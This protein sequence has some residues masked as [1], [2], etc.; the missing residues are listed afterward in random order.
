MAE[1][2]RD[3]DHFGLCGEEQLRSVSAQLMRF[4]SDGWLRIGAIHHNPVMLSADD[5]S[6]LRD[7]GMFAEVVAPRLNL[8]LHGHTHEGKI[9]SLGQDGLPVLALAALEC[10]SR[11]AL[12]TCRTST[13][14][15]G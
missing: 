12:M 10:G 14:R 8:L 4:E 1:S 6:S 7:A 5:N 2:H 15:C 3:D 13:R 11:H 9:C